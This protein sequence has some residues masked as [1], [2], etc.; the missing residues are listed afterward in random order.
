M[1]LQM[2]GSKVITLTLSVFYSTILIYICQLLVANYLISECKS[3]TKKVEN[4]CITI[5]KQCKNTK[6]LCDN[7]LKK[8][9]IITI[10][11]EIFPPFRKKR[12]WKKILVVQCQNRIKAVKIVLFSPYKYT[13]VVRKERSMD[14]YLM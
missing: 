9:H 14:I 4:H 3:F 2:I 13:S 8:I 10:T 12:I 1:W 11:I 7:A 5:T 6:T